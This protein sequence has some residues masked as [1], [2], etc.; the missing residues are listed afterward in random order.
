LSIDLIGQARNTMKIPNVTPNFHILFWRTF[1]PRNPF[2]SSFCSFPNRQTEFSTAREAF[3]PNHCVAEWAIHQRIWLV[4]P[5]LF[6][7]SF[8]QKFHKDVKYKLLIHPSFRKGRCEKTG[9]V[10]FHIIPRFS[11]GQTPAG[12]QCFH[13]VTNTLD[14]G[15]HRGDEYSVISSQLQGGWGGLRV[16]DI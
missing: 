2:V 1:R 11:S 13:E 6:P 10:L 5:S 7:M 15:F 16:S 14:S 12:I 4:T 3:F 8:L 9:L